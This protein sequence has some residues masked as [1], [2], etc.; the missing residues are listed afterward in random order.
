[1]GDVDGPGPPPD[2]P[3]LLALPDDILIVIL[4]N[5]RVRGV[6]FTALRPCKRDHSCSL[7]FFPS[8]TAYPLAQGRDLAALSLTCKVWTTRTTTAGLSIASAGA[9]AALD[10]GSAEFPLAQSAR[11]E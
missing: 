3:S 5:L 6:T 1:M 8:R 2:G 7:A 4:S 9:K 11:E 10:A